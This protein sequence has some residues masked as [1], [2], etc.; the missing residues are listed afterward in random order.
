MRDL[1]RSG[2]PIVSD[3]TVDS[4]RDAFL[5]SS[6]ISTPRISRK[7]QIPQSKMVKVFI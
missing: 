1:K 3:E 4:V 5:R 6:R 7:L 2:R